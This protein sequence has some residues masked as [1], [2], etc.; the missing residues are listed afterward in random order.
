MRGTST[1]GC[2]PP[3][4]PMRNRPDAARDQRS[5]DT[6]QIRLCEA[7][8]QS[9]RAKGIAPLIDHQVHAILSN[10]STPAA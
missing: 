9:L 1:T 4:S 8:R 2:W 7:I 10:Y 6:S 3:L 5:A